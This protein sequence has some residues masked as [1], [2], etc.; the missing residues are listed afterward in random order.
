[1]TA[2]SY[3][4]EVREQYETYPYPHRDP[5]DEKTRLLYTWQDDLAQINHYCYRGKNAFKDPLRVLVAGGGTGDAVV[6]LAEQL[7]NA[8]AEVVY[9]DI[10]RSSME[11]AQKRA[12]VRKLS[13]ITWVHGSLLEISALNLGEFGYITCSGVL[14][15]LQDPEDGLDK[16]RSVLAPGGALSIMV[17]GKYGRTGIYQIQ[18]LMR[19]IN[20]NTRGMQESL[21]NTKAILACLPPSNQWKKNEGASVDLK[22]P[23]AEIYDFFLHSQDRAYTVPEL[24][25]WIDRRCGLHMQL[26]RVDYGRM[27]YTPECYIWDPA[28]L[29]IVKALPV[30]EQQAVAELIAGNIDRHCFYAMQ[31]A[32]TAATL[33]ELDNVP[34]FFLGYAS[35]KGKDIAEHIR[36]NPGQRLKFTEP[37]TTIT[38][39]LAPG[40]YSE[41]LLRHL[42]G[43]RSLRE[44]FELARNDMPSG[45]AGV[46]DAQLLEDFR[47]IFDLFNAA[48]GMLLRHKSV[49]RFPGIAELHSLS[50]VS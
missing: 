6:F 21:V 7:R 47:P 33:D 8:D 42:D 13:N 22:T 35:I 38:L 44:I 48:E 9:L 1:M 25:D 32:G 45:G 49:S 31:S 29:K 26:S 39:V 40:K 11:I 24:Y 16:L 15:H 14:H 46:T 28:L 37:T 20:R 30:P 43:E 34:F 27:P 18:D 10:S 41:Q 3:L 19:I 17:Y 50:R 5:E 4:K 2:G 12:E 36:K 23:D